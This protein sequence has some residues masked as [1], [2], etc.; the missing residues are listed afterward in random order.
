MDGERREQII[1]I[2]GTSIPVSF[3]QIYDRGMGFY[4]LTLQARFP[5]YNY[6]PETDMVSFRRDSS[7][8]CFLLQKENP[9]LLT[10]S[11]RI[12]REEISYPS[13]MVRIVEHMIEEFASSFVIS[14]KK[15]PIFNSFARKS[16]A[17]IKDIEDLGFFRNTK[18]V[19]IEKIRDM[20]HKK[21]IE[22][23]IEIFEEIKA[24][25]ESELAEQNSFYRE[26]TARLMKEEQER[27][28]KR[29]ESTEKS[30]RFLET[31]VPKDILEKAKE[32]GFLLVK[33]AI[34]DFQI[35][36]SSHG[37]VS[38][39]KDGNKECDYCLQFQ[40]YSIPVGD[41]VAMKYTLLL[42]DPETFILKANKIRRERCTQ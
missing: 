23:K 28:R 37:L 4:E 16:R 22:E 27:E 11:H 9:E 19:I 2:G 31:I 7:P 21:D 34:G 6:L 8:T 5:E 38:F 42:S 1:L 30:W 3:S 20:I 26:R 17:T 25:Y 36:L 13:A 14:I 12:S 29:I 18:M 10:V 32:V 40:D 33:N 41:E 15:Y 24:K 39:F 35:P